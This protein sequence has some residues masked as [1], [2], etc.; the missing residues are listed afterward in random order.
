MNN[1]SKLYSRFFF[2]PGFIPLA[3]GEKIIGYLWLFSFTLATTLIFPGLII[4]GV[5]L[6]KYC[7]SDVKK[8]LRGDITK[9]DIF[10]YL[11][12]IFTEYKEE[13]IEKITEYKEQQT[14]KNYDL[15][16]EKANESNFKKAI[17]LLNKISVDHQLYNDSQLKLK[18]YNDS[19]GNI[20]INNAISL[21]EEYQ[22]LKAIKFLKDINKSQTVS[23]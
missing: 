13:Q 22:Y 6:Y 11:S 4:W 7:K 3:K 14:I 5:Y 9:Q 17:K 18:E 10:N 21:A 1:N 16:I 12:K 23:I 15:A 19:Y 8:L 2:I 20:L